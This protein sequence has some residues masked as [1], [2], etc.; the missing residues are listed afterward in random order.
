MCQPEHSFPPGFHPRSPQQSFS[1]ETA[2]LRGYQNAAF[3]PAVGP[4]GSQLRVTQPLNPILDRFPGPLLLPTLVVRVPQKTDSEIC[5]EALYWRGF[6]FPK[7]GKW[8]KQR[9]RL[10]CDVVEG[11]LPVPWATLGRRGLQSHPKVTQEAS[12][13]RPVF[14]REFPQG[15]GTL[16]KAACL[17]QRSF[18]GMDLAVSLWQ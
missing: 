3:P 5:M 13:H 2:S 6:G 1:E 4:Q 12:T 17:S 7:W 16:G 11:P 8:V 10:E 18:W 9:K 14:K 15:G